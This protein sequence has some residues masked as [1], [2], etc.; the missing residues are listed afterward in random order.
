MN[1]QL[2]NIRLP[3]QNFS[4]TSYSSQ[5]E[6]VS[7]SGVS[8]HQSDT[9]G[10]SGYFPGSNQKNPI[11]NSNIIEIPKGVNNTGYSKGNTEGMSLR[12]TGKYSSTNVSSSSGLS[13]YGF[14]PFPNKSVNSSNDNPKALDNYQ[15]Y[16]VT[17]P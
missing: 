14:P 5:K 1:Q 4:M 8:T 6:T 12:P 7:T 15:G 11:W 3:F 17:A 9:N 16:P 10:G 13:N 2:Q